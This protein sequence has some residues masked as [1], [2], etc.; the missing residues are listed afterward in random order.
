MRHCCPAA[1]VTICFTRAREP[2]RTAPQTA[3]PSVVCGA[4]QSYAGH[5]GKDRHWFKAN[6]GRYD[7]YLLGPARELA[8]SLERFGKP[9]FFRPYNNVRFHPGPPLKEHLGVAI[10][11]TAAGG[12]YLELSLDGLL[13]AAGLHHPAT[14]QLERF[15]AAIDD[16][17][18]ATAFERTVVSAEA[19][20]LKLAQ[21]AIKRA[22]RGY[23]IDHPRTDL[24]NDYYVQCAWRGACNWSRGWQGRRCGHHLRSQSKASA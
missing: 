13:V 12:S 7:E 2:P 23:R 19:G 24:G 15:R 5:V 20:C 8:A 4:L 9:R 1:C 17:R 10:G 14:D 18:R 22:P 21:P 11:N 16:H 6:R 3:W